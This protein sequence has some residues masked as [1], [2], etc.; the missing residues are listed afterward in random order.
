MPAMPS[1]RCTLTLPD[2]TRFDWTHNVSI[3]LRQQRPWMMNFGSAL[4]GWPT[5]H[6]RLSEKPHRV[7]HSVMALT[8]EK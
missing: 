6:T 4:L 2:R 1:R 8:V 3:Q 7:R 5:L